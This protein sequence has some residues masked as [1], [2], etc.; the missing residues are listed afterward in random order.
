MTTITP[1]GFV[2]NDATPQD[3]PGRIKQRLSRIRILPSY[4]P[5]LLGIEKHLYLVVLFGLDKVTETHLHESLYAGG[6]CGIFACRSQFRPNRL[7]ITT[8]RLLQVSGHELIVQGLDAADGSPVFDLKCPDTS[9]EEQKMIHRSVLRQH[10]R[11]DIDYMIRNRT[12]F[13]LW[14]KA[15]EL[16]GALSRELALGVMAALHFMRQVREKKWDIRMYRLYAPFSS[17]LTDGA[18]YVS[19][20]TPGSGRLFEGDEPDVLAF[21][22][23]EGVWRYA[24]SNYPAEEEP[25]ES[26]IDRDPEN[27]FDINNQ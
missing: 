5:G 21:R 25:V 10:P 12:P 23:A 18:L 3:R 15:G 11:H 22:G 14:L 16:T 20:L 27:Y 9:E 13:L 8:C 1:I 26:W 7:G 6:E 17:P 4:Q 24:L 19:G 2:S